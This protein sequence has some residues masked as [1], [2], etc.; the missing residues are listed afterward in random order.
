[1]AKMEKKK[2]WKEIPMAGLI[3]EAGN[4]DEYETGS[5]RTFKPVLDKEACN[6]C[7]IC[8]I[9]CPDTSIVVENEEMVGFDY[10]HCK[11]CGICAAECPK[12][13]IEMVL[14]QEE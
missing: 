8:W 14:D 11:G 7:L 5:W 9:F 13:A 6:N 10:V 4:A 12:K 3:T 1:M 2:G